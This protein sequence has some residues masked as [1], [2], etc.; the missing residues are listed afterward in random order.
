M[1]HGLGK[2]QCLEA[3]QQDEQFG[4]RLLECL[5]VGMLAWLAGQHSGADGTN[6][7]MHGFVNR[8]HAARGWRVKRLEFGPVRHE[9]VPETAK[10][11]RQW[12]DHVFARGRAQHGAA[13]DPAAPFHM[14][15]DRGI[16]FGDKN[17]GF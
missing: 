9:P 2:N 15:L 17:I 16:E 14:R 4:L 5:Q 13:Q 10:G 11:V 12:V 6:R 1:P 8:V 7:V 3:G